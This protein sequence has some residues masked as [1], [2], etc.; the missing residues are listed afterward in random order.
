MRFGVSAELR[1]YSKRHYTADEIEAL[2][3]GEDI[4]VL[5]VHDAP[6][7]VRFER[8]RQGQGYVSEARG[9]DELVRRA[10]PRVC[11]FGHHH[12]R[13]DA[14]I[15]G[16]RCLGLNKVARPGNLVAFEIAAGRPDWRH[17]GEWP[18]S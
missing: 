8:H 17:L 12:T 15:A 2:S 14:E 1:G 10:R 9:L 4:D 5:L 7:G 16:V 11:F 6:A 3:T 13:V 18:K